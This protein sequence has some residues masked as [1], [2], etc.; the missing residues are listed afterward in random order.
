VGLQPHPLLG[1]RRE[2][3]HPEEAVHADPVRH[4]VSST[5]LSEAQV[6]L[7]VAYHAAYPGKVDARIAAEPTSLPGC[8]PGLREAAPE[9]DV[10]V[11]DRKAGTGRK[12][13]LAACPHVCLPVCMRMHI[14]LGD[15]LVRELDR[16]VGRGHRSAFIAA[17]IT[18]A[19]DDA[20]RWELILST[21]G[22]IA[23]E[24]HAWDADPAAW[25]R[26]ERRGTAARVG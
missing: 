26:D 11:R 24:G 14:T 3:R 9:R 23:D 15:D 2:S 4:V 1:E 18:R 21:A 13:H 6:V 22:A 25:V 5:D 7:A 20:R 16:R 19:L 10:V 17:T 12:G 8:W